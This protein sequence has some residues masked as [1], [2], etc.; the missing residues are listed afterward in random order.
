MSCLFFAHSLST[1]LLPTFTLGVTLIMPPSPRF[2]LPTYLRLLTT[3]R[4]TFSHIAPPVA[5]ALRHTPCLDPSK[6][7]SKGIDLSSV[8][9]FVSGGAP[10]PVEVIRAVY[11]RTGRYIQIG[12]GTTEGGGST[13]AR[14]L[15]LDEA[16]KRAE[17]GSCGLPHSNSEVRILPTPGVS[18]SVGQAKEK[19]KQESEGLVEP[20]EPCEP[21]E[22]LLKGP[23]I[24][25]G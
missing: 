15:D 8:K 2:H 10:V 21:G 13:Q 12:Y 6:P 9:A 20:L 1:L 19:V 11:K 18:Q 7:D 5:V 22:V 4:A 16:S 17:L 25:L 23:T 3:Y 14:A 24:M